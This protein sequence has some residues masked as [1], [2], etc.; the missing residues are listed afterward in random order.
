MKINF[1]KKEYRSLLEIIN[2]ADWVMHCHETEDK[3]NEYKQLMKKIRSFCK[4]MGAEDCLEYDEELDDYFEF[5]D[6][7]EEIQEKFIEPYDF[8]NF[9]EELAE[10]LAARDLEEKL[11]KK[12]IEALSGMDRIFKI[13]EEKEKY[14][15]EFEKHGIERLRVIK[16]K[17]L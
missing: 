5:N 1:T 4:E 10:E 11:S 16:N 9:W 13:E 2:V 14:D 12:E 8:Q 15:R 7:E 3:D 17:N 6:F